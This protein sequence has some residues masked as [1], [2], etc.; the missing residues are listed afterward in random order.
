MP[1]HTTQTLIEEDYS[2]S[3]NNNANIPTQP[4]FIMTPQQ[5]QP[6]Q[7]NGFFGGFGGII[8][9]V[10]AGIVLSQ[11]GVPHLPGNIKF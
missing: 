4:V 8:C 10:L 5:P 2:M 9:S 1:S 6:Q 11:L 7:D 3:K